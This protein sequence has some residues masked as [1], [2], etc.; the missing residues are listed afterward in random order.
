[1]L[2][3]YV[4]YHGLFSRPVFRCMRNMPSRW[5]LKVWVA[6]TCLSLVY[7]L[8]RKEIALECAI[9]HCSDLALVLCTNHLDVTY[10]SFHG[11]SGRW[12]YRIPVWSQF[13]ISSGHTSSIST[14]STTSSK[15]FCFTSAKSVAVYF[16]CDVVTFL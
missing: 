6:S 10:S 9:K 7:Q 12:N 14:V 11:P 2:C 16:L 3:M 13:N 4:L 5:K 1:M 8:Y 15:N